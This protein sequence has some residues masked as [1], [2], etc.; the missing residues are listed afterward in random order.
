MN[1]VS[2]CDPKE[3]AKQDAKSFG[4]EAARW[5]GPPTRAVAKMLCGDGGNGTPA[6]RGEEHHAMESVLCLALQHVWEGKA[7]LQLSGTARAHAQLQQ[8][9]PGLLSRES[10]I[11]AQSRYN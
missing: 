3:K 1:V 4:V 10:L 6:K 5:A 7:A 9:K 8:G 11:G 2:N